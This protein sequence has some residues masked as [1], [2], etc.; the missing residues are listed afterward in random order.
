MNIDCLRIIVKTHFNEML[1]YTIEREIFDYGANWCGGPV[2]YQAP[3]EDIIKYQNL[4]AVFLLYKKF[5]TGIFPWCAAF[6]QT[7]DIIKK[8]KDLPYYDYYQNN[9]LDYACQS[10]NGEICKFLLNS[11]NANDK[12][13]N[14]SNEGRLSTPLHFAAKWNNKEATE[15]LISHGANINEKYQEGKQLFILQHVIIVKK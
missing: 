14:E 5:K 7:I 8:E 9:I 13:V 15:L 1:E 6:P 4:K 2:T 10:Q 3:F 11:T 12:Y